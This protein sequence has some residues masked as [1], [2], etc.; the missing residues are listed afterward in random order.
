MQRGGLLL[1][2]AVGH[3]QLTLL[4]LQLFGQRLRLFQ[5][6]FGPHGGGDGVQHNAE[7]F[8][9]LIEKRQMDLAEPLE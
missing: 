5:Q 6:F 8:G 1:E 4:R 3:R 9:E 2:A 7:A